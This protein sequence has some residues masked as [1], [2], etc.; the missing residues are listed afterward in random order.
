MAGKRQHSPS[1]AP[2][3]IYFSTPI[4]EQTS[5]FTA[6]FSPS[7]SAKALQALPEFHSATHRIAAWRKPSRQMS[8]M[9]ASHTL[10]DT[11]HDDDGEKWAGTRLSNVLRDTSTCGTVVVGRWYGGQNIGPIR[12]THIESS[13][14]EAIRKAKAAGASS[15]DSAQQASSSASH[16]KQKVQVKVQEEGEQEEARRKELISNLQERDYNI[17]ALR[18]LLSEKKARLQGEG[19]VELPTP[20]KLMDYDRMSME[21][22]ERVDKARDATI[23]FILKQIDRIEEE[24][25]LAETLDRGGGEDVLKDADKNKQEEALATPE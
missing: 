13:A 18:K 23:A 19:R 15:S 25:K 21:A 2:P 14:K 3:E 10:Y 17:F 12:F 11:G 8:L 16:K 20:Q 4:H 9:P 1:P 24:A 22:L 6:A 7:L 5:S